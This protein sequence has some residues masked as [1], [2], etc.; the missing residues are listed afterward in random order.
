VS[1]FWERGWIR[2]LGILAC[3]A[4]LGWLL[5]VLRG[6]FTPFAV[7]FGLA[8]F[9]N[10]A[11]SSLEHL[12]ERS[13]FFR[14]R[15]PRTFAVALLT[16]GVL[17]VFVVL[18]LVVVPKVIDQV[19][20]TGAKLPEWVAT[21]RGRAEPLIQRLD[22][23]YPAEVEQVQRKLEQ[24]IQE[25][26][27][28][29]LT[30]VPG[31][32][33]AIFSNLL[34]FVLFVLQVVAVPVFTVYL[35]ADMNRFRE[36]VSRL[37][38]V[39]YQGYV[40]SRV[41]KI[42]HLLAAFVRGQI[43]LCLILGTFY[44]ISLTLAGVPMGLLVGFVVGFFILVPYMPTFL[45]LPLVAL[46]TFIDKKSLSAVLTVTGIFV[47]GQI[48]EGHFLTPRIMGGTLGLHP[49]VVML[50]VLVGGTLFGFVGMLLA[51]PT[52]AALSVFWADLRE[53]YLQSDFYRRAEAPRVE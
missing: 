5:V 18:A 44:A 36:G 53:L 37:V 3:L 14:A 8:Y 35:L 19:R 42:D 38:P 48:V 43:T 40:R 21:L 52:T 1:A 6:V 13:A 29:L 30:P 50:A 39:R 2:L 12:F 31:F 46:L 49:V 10:P 11:V 22:L 28:R 41:E 32:V 23:R 16:T 51:V 34:S 47:F 27:P 26:L 9:L 24:M 7:A 17:L 15:E 20:E 45:G 25:N 33:G 4:L